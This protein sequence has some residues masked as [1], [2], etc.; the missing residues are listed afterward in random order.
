MPSRKG[1]IR[2]LSRCKENNCRLKLP[3]SSR[4]FRRKKILKG[5]DYVNSV[6]KPKNKLKACD[7]IVILEISSGGEVL[8]IVELKDDVV[9]ERMIRKE[10]IEKFRNTLKAVAHNGRL[11]DVWRDLF[12][13]ARSYDP[14]TFSPTFWKLVNSNKLELHENGETF[15]LKLKKCG[16]ELNIQEK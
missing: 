8:V 5:E 11:G 1:I 14:K 3:S 4:G 16:Y 12:I 15:V 13:L 10:I 6:L 7:C 2:T 9:T